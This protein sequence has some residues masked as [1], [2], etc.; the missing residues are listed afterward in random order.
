MV[1]I[2]GCLTYEV[3]PK[4]VSNTEVAE[5]YADDGASCVIQTLVTVLV[6]TVTSVCNTKLLFNLKFKLKSTISFVLLKI[7]RKT[8]TNVQFVC[9]YDIFVR[10][11]CF[12]KT[13]VQKYVRTYEL[14]VCTSFS[15]NF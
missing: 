4:R 15:Y 11:F 6:N 9:S 1:S 8:C 12:S 7:V 2:T 10:M 5:V 13:F 3:Q 14:Y